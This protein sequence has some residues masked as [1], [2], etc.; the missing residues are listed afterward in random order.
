MA[1]DDTGDR[2]ALDDGL[3]T[4]VTEASTLG[5]APGEWPDNFLDDGD[6]MFRDRDVRHGGELVAVVYRSRGGREL[7]VMND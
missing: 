4:V 1:L 5:W 3:T 7:E 2:D 6:R